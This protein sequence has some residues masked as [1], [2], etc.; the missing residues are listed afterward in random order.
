MREAVNRSEKRV[1][2]ETKINCLSSLNSTQLIRIGDDDCRR[3]NGSSP[4]Q[5]KNNKKET[6]KW[7]KNGENTPPGWTDA[8]HIRL[9]KLSE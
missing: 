4:W 9:L 2:N 8:L 6:G 5:Q 7:W 1:K 3:G